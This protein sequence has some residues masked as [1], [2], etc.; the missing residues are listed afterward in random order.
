M[1]T[2]F[3]A[4]YRDWR[5]VHVETEKLGFCGCEV[6]LFLHCL[7]NRVLDH[8]LECFH[9]LYSRYRDLHLGILLRTRYHALRG[10]IGRTRGMNGRGD[11]MTVAV[12]CKESLR[13]ALKA[14]NPRM[15]YLIVL[16]PRIGELS[17]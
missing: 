4:L 12:E 10:D 8:V 14:E 15:S 3:E 9:P 2:V 17:I 6:S 5:T 16:R 1:K 11:S 13:A 7:S